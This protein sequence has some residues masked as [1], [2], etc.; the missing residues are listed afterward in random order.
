MAEWLWRWTADL[1]RTLRACSIPVTGDF[2]SF[3][4]DADGGVSRSGA[5]ERKLRALKRVQSTKPKGAK[6][7]SRRA[8]MSA[9]NVGASI[10]YMA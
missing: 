10:G 9:V 7:P 1:K 8:R 3:F 4:N 5:S 6:R 2:F